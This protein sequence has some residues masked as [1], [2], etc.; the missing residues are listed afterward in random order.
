MEGIPHSLIIRHGLMPVP[1]GAP[2]MVSRSILASDDHLMAMASS[3][4]G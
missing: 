2:S 4:M 3:R 1:P